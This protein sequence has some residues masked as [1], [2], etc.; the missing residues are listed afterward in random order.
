MVRVPA[1]ML[2]TAGPA[3]SD[4]DPRYAY[5]WKYDGIRCLAGISEGVCHMVSR[6]GSSLK[7]AF[8]EIAHELLALAA[9]REMTLDGELVTP[10]RNG[11]PRF[12]RIGRRLGVMRPS[13][14]LIQTVPTQM[15]VFD[16][17]GLDGQ[18]LRPRTYLDRREHLQRLPLP[19]G[20]ILLS[21]SYRGIPV[22]RMLEVAAEHQVE[23]VIG[24]RVDSTYRSGRSQAWRKLPLRRA[25]EVVVVGWLAGRAGSD[26]FGSLLVAAHDPN[27]HLVLLGAVGTGFTDAARRVLHHELLALTTA[28]P[29]VAGAVPSSIAATAHWVL[30]HLVGDVAYRERTASGL[31]HPSWRGLRFDRSP[32]EIKVPE[33]N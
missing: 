2:A 14:S 8:P 7:P 6:N 33:H 15:Y 1:P 25:T 22:S 9:G 4:D 27:G 23:G 19:H 5:E 17:L 30:P 11:V 13:Q 29:P 16:L 21:P 32:T 31:R 26:V 12:S 20:P 24:K 3:P 18:D 10:D 28:E